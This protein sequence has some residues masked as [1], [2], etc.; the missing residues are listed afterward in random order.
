M[1]SITIFLWK[2]FIPNTVEVLY[3]YLTLGRKYRM[4]EHEYNYDLM[5]LR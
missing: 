4:T 5:I 3:F 1:N 2:T